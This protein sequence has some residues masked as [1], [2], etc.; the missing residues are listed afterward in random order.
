MMMPIL[1]TKLYIPLSRRK[2][3]E[4]TRLIEQLNDG[5]DRKLI[6]IT[7]PAGFG[8]TTLTSEWIAQLDCPVAWLS[9][10]ENDSDETRFL[11]YIIAALQTI[12]PQI[13]ASLAEVLQARQLPSI[14]QL[15]TT[16]LNDITILSD[17]FVLILDDYH[18]IENATIDKGIT[19]LLDYLPPNMHLVIMTREDPPLPL[20]RLRARGQLTEIRASDL[21]FS[22]DEVS[23]FFD[24]GM[25][26]QLSKQDIATLEA[27]TEGWVAGLQLAGLS[28]QGA[29]NITDLIQSFS[30]T[31]HF[32][33]D[34]LVEEVLHRQPDHIQ[35]F[36]LHTSI[37]K[38][39]SGNLCD[40]LMMDDGVSGQ[41]ILE[42]IHQANL[43]LVPLDNQRQ[44]YRYHHL[45]GDLLQQRLHQQLDET[46]I[47]Q[48]HH[49][50]STWY[51]HQNLRT[52]AI[53][54]ALAAEDFEQAA[55]LI[56]LVWSETHSTSFHSPAQ[57]KWMEAI[58]YDVR[59]HRPVLS[60]GYAWTL[61]DFGELD[62]VDMCLRDA[63]QYFDLDPSMDDL[64]SDM[65]VID[66]VAFQQLPATVAAA[67]TYLSMAMG[68]IPD[69][70]HYA[71][72]VLDLSS[73]DELHQRGMA[74]SLL[75]LANWWIGNLS[76]AYQSMREGMA[77]MHKMG[78][79]SFA[80][81]NTFGMAD[82]Q[83]A[84]GR[85]RDA[86]VTYEQSMEVAKAQEGT[87]QGVADLLMGLG[88]LYRE[89]NDLE[90][91]QAYLRDSENLGEQAKL[92]NW[93]YRFC[94]IQSRMMRTL[95]DLDGALDL[96]NEAESIYY[97]TPVPN[98]RPTAAY[99]AIIWIEQGHIDKALAWAYEQHRSLDAE[100]TYLN[101][102]EL[103]VL[104]RIYIVQYQQNN[105][106]VPIYE[107]ENL[108]MR[109]LEAAELGQR[110]GSVIEI[111]I[112]Q[113]LL[114][115][116]L[117]NTGS[118]LVALQRALGLAEPEG[119]SRIFIDEG[120]PMKE[121]LAKTHTQNGASTYVNTLLATFENNQSTPRLTSSQSLIEPL[122]ERE[123]EVLQLIADGL[124]N[125]EISE[126]LYL[127][128]STVKGHNRNIFD[129]LGVKRRTE[130]V[131]RANELDL[132]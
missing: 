73:D 115:R 80:L 43:F 59:R 105:A 56:E 41:D 125:R 71:Q 102:F 112:L 66:D 123:L 100:V 116:V 88:D 78:N 9:L 8:K 69:A 104:A 94:L 89:Q 7:A 119:Y 96:L 128:L 35:T 51:D 68:N 99:K 14:D 54:H 108:L 31:H 3:V 97:V 61:L 17:D 45:F 87:V 53:Y 127:A 113:A 49:R 20:S 74:S 72:R 11:A 85:L 64:A 120:A 98:V 95:G 81:S 129:K 93:R 83:I 90:S 4:R 86:I 76:A 57:R 21:R 46:H 131:A 1:A 48:L 55:S 122:S 25:G 44:W 23:E 27:R 6:L 62:A 124:S 110:N 103:M 91:A 58:P 13:G 50:A 36:L 37:L 5:F 2:S 38:R 130:A 30:G 65:I 82:V 121:L 12:E 18:V 84:Q 101:E 117:N 77:I 22:G 92:P 33:L 118:G 60:T 10:D 29:K 52:E 39:L 79:V 111:L 70:I 26:I 114:Q 132:L 34:Y 28:M 16:L 126:R 24:R 15:L 75:G 109:L 106:S 32:V 42:T 107:V 40:A 67:R 19:F 47:K 63:E